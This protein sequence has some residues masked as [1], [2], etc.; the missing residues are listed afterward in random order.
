MNTYRCNTSCFYFHFKWQ[1]LFSLQKWCYVQ[2][3]TFWSMQVLYIKATRLLA[4]LWLMYDEYICDWAWNEEGISINNSVHSLM[5]EVAGKLALKQADIASFTIPLE[6]CMG[7]WF[8]VMFKRFVQVVDF[9]KIVLV[10]ILA[11]SPRFSSKTL[12]LKRYNYTKKHFII[13][14]QVTTETTLHISWGKILSII[15]APVIQLSG[16][17]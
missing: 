7:S 4:V 5:I 3:Y 9:H 14:L 6:A 12:H 10:S 11:Q 2:G 8:R 15:W 13:W 16:R 1:L 17:R